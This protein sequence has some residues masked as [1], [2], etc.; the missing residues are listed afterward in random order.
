MCKEK[1]VK[2]FVSCVLILMLS[3]LSLPV[4]ATAAAET[5]LV[6]AFQERKHLN[7]L[8]TFDFS[9]QAI[10]SLVYRGLFMID[11]QEMLRK[12][13]A[14]E[15]MWSADH[16]ALYISLRKD[17][18]FS[19]KEPLHA[20]D[21]AYSILYYRFYLEQYLATEGY[22]LY[23]FQSLSAGDDTSALTSLSPADFVPSRFI[24]FR[25]SSESSADDWQESLLASGDP[26]SEDKP[27]AFTM[28]D[29][30]EYFSFLET[31]PYGQNALRTIR[32]IEVIDDSSFVIYLEE[33]AERLPWVLCLPLIPKEY[34]ESFS[35]DPIPGIGPYIME[36]RPVSPPLSEK[37]ATEEEEADTFSEALEKSTLE[38][39]LPEGDFQ[40][41][42][43][44]DS[45]VTA[46]E[47]EEAGDEGEQEENIEEE[48]IEIKELYLL[49]SSRSKRNIR[50]LKVE[51]FPSFDL[52]LTAYTEGR[53]DVLLVEKEI[54]HNMALQQNI[55]TV[56]QETREFYFL[57]SGH[58]PS[59]IFSD[60]NLCKQFRHAMALTTKNN[61][62]KSQLPFPH[63]L[64]DWRRKYAVYEQDAS[65]PS[66]DWQ[67]LKERIKD[68]KIVLAAVSNGFNREIMSDVKRLFTNL[69][70][71]PELV[72]LSEEEYV[73]FAQRGEY[74]FL[75]G[76]VN[77]S[78]PT[79]YRTLNIELGKI[80][81]EFTFFS[82][83]FTQEGLLS[84]GFFYQWD[85]EDSG[86]SADAI[87]NSYRSIHEMIED[88]RV[89][90]LFFAQQGLLLSSRVQGTISSPAYAPYRNIEEL[91]LWE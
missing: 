61:P 22:G 42:D 8:S 14:A 29:Q 10:M 26:D 50:E 84:P 47:P 82:N 21:A 1:V 20:E 66:A 37:Q 7:P 28:T 74:D 40:S 53:I 25:D 6:L 51:A 36:M 5:S 45:E 34:T 90:E 77:L 17:E 4:F 39:D 76:C 11:D 9:G 46:K 13:L 23:A 48:S 83:Y 85:I 81:S 56:A 32:L 68:E 69:G 16:L 65:I 2:V 86:L 55:H 73:A 27:T 79:D 38:T 41:E 72:W 58:S 49:P 24:T 75:L 70:A 59:F 89:F 80:S 33:H 91:S 3:L 64:R 63:S 87:R 35:L 78:Y 52:A 71:R 88:I 12:D 67:N 43:A 15:A 19:H 31:D 54:F 60:I 30:A 57:L 18:S 44:K 62:L